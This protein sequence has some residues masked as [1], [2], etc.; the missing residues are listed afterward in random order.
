M[1]DFPLYGLSEEHQAVREAVRA[2]CD[3]KIAPFA[4]EVDEE[5]RYP[6][7]AADALLAADFHAPRR[8]ESWEVDAPWVG[9]SGAGGNLKLAGKSVAR[10]AR[11]N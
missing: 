4:A 2:L 10:S 5:A 11:S 9:W 7:E 6:Q 3:A 1:T 8:A